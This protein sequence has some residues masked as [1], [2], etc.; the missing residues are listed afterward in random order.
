MAT[1]TTR[2]PRKPRTTPRKAT[3]RSVAV[4]TGGIEPFRF[5]TPD[6]EPEVELVELFSIDDRSYFI[7]KEISPSVSLRFM[8]AARSTGMEIAMADLLESM[9]GEEAFEALANYKHITTQ[10]FADL[11]DLVRRHA[12]GAITGPKGNSKS[13]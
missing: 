12:M 1:T 3:V 6:I 9:L 4:P 7:P 8:R 11:M 5:V 13:A 10:Q 2:A